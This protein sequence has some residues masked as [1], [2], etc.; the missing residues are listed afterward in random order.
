[1]GD[2]GSCSILNT[3]IWSLAR[4]SENSGFYFL[5]CRRVVYAVPVHSCCI[6][7]LQV[8]LAAFVLPILVSDG[9]VSLLEMM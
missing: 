8:S 6:G 5:C 2:N 4:W 3:T 1:M 9:A 7:G